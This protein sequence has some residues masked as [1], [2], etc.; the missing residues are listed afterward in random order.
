MVAPIE[1]EVE[2]FGAVVVVIVVC[3]VMARELVVVGVGFIINSRVIP[4]SS[5]ISEMKD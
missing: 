5:R 1:T 4:L 2:L 3:A